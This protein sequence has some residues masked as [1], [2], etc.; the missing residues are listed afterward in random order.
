MMSRIKILV[1]EDDEGILEL[2]K[3]SLGDTTFEKRF[4]NSGKEALAIYQAWRPDI[5]VLDIWMPLMTGYLALQEIRGVMN[6]KA[7][8]II[9]STSASNNNDIKDCLKFDIQGY[10]LKPFKL[11]EIGTKI[12]QYYQQHKT[13]RLH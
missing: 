9:M 2:Y 11:A 5:I 7:T 4:A 8:T 10:I 3:A 1:A 13:N 6:D 12:I